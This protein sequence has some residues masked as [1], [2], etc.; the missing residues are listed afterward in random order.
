VTPIALVVAGLLVGAWLLDTA[1]ASR[2]LRRLGRPAVIARPGSGVQAWWDRQR[3]RTDEQDDA[4]ALALFADLVAAALEAGAPVETALTVVA[5][6]VPGPSTARFLD[7]AL[8]EVRGSPAPST[9]AS[10]WGRPRPS[11]HTGTLLRALRRSGS[12]GARLA[13]QLHLVA[14]DLRAEQAAA[15]V[16]RARRVGVTAVLP[17]GLCCLPAFMLLAVVPLGV[18]LL[19]TLIR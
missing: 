3:S 9:P 4:A 10:G 11:D 13:A 8:P 2:P 6:A 5:R 16:D 14:D 15:A 7:L 12:S 17:L 1:P 18:G 19:R